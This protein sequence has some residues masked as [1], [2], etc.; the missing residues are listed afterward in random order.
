MDSGKSWSNKNFVSKC[1][2]KEM[3]LFWSHHETQCFE[4][5]SSKET[6]QERGKEEN[7]RQHG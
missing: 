7:Q 5:I 6:D 1:K 4:K 2:D 3:A